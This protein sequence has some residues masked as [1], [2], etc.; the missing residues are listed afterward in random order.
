MKSEIVTFEKL[1]IFIQHVKR[2]KLLED[3]E[4]PIY[5]RDDLFK[6]CSEKRRPPYRWIVIGP[7]RSGTGIHIDPLGKNPRSWRLS[8][9]SFIKKNVC[10][11]VLLPGMH[12]FLGTN[13]GAFFQLILL[14][15][16]SRLPQLKVES[17][18]VRFIHYLSWLWKMLVIISCTFYFQMKQLLGS[19]KYIQRL[20]V[21]TGQRNTNQ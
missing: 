9:H 5:F 4:V 19:P 15:S 16:L 17:N 8:G 2:Q 10:S 7:P 1:F 3:Y 12:L 11:Q 18:R 13:V 14:K 21:L 6:Y 20:K